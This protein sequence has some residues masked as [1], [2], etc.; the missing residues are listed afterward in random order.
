MVAVADGRRPDI[1]LVVDP[2]MVAKRL[3]ADG[4]VLR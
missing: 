3:A 1:P 4:R 2:V